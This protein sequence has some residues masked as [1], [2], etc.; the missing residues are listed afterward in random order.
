MLCGIFT[1]RNVRISEKCFLK[2]ECSQFI[3]N[4]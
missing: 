3:R 4:E 1:N 2:A